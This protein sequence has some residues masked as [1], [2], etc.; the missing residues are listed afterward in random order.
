MSRPLHVITT[1]MFSPAKRLRSS[2][3]A[4]QARAASGQGQEAE[5]EHDA[6]ALCLLVEPDRDAFFNSGTLCRIMKSLKAVSP[7]ARREPP[8]P[9]ALLRVLGELIQRQGVVAQAPTRWASREE[10]D[11]LAKQVVDWLELLPP[12][13]IEAL[14]VAASSTAA[15]PAHA[16]VTYASLQL[17]LRAYSDQLTDGQ[18]RSPS[19]RCRH[20][21]NALM[22]INSFGPPALLVAGAPEAQP[23]RLGMTDGKAVAAFEPMK[24]VQ[25]LPTIAP[26]KLPARY[27]RARIDLVTDD[28][29]GVEEEEGN[30]TEEGEEPRLLLD[31]AQMECSAEM[32]QEIAEGLAT[33]TTRSKKITIK[34]DSSLADCMSLFVKTKATLSKPVGTYQDDHS[35][36]TVCAGAASKSYDDL[37]FQNFLQQAIEKILVPGLDQLPPFRSI[38]EALEKHLTADAVHHAIMAYRKLATVKN[39]DQAE[40]RQTARKIHRRYRRACAHDDVS[41]S[42]GDDEEGDELA[43]PSQEAA[44]RELRTDQVQDEE[45]RAM[46]AMLDGC[47]DDVSQVHLKAIGRA[48]E[49]AWRRETASS[50]RTYARGK[51]APEAR[52]APSNWP[53]KPSHRTELRK[54]INGIK[55]HDRDKA[56]RQ[57]LVDFGRARVMQRIAN[58]DAKEARTRTQTV[59]SVLSC[60]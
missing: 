23:E 5:G 35:F 3:E 40:A 46:Q 8:T 4:L 19:D 36:W 44:T 60:G 18:T 38:A 31:D 54:F 56:L 2:L 29:M 13:T 12:E 49:V 48:A 20:S 11:K 41:E 45:A 24:N 7:A 39:S 6:Y 42:S 53:A 10:A 14:V 52:P 47:T 28:D 43:E 15:P 22:I 17:A 30:E 59:R 27:G 55:Q 50:E 33:A 37:S 57:H 16:P 34:A 58:D 32:E 21:A 1:D 25:S 26:S 51:A 9:E